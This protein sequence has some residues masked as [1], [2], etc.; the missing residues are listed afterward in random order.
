M[1]IA[2]VAL[3]DI[4]TDVDMLARL[5]VRVFIPGQAADDVAALLHRFI[6]QFRCTGIAHDAFLRKRHDLDVAI[7][8]EFFTG[9]QQT[10][11]GT[12]S[13][14]RAD[15]GEQPDTRRAALYT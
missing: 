1:N 14:D 15:A 11:R 4:E 9:E 10:P 6:E 13:P 12:T 7:A 2:V 8:A 5:G 3:G